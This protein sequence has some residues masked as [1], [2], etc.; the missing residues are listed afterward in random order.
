MKKLITLS[1]CF[2]AIS[3]LLSPLAYAQNKDYSGKTLLDAYKLAGDMKI[4]MNIKQHYAENQ[5]KQETTEK[6]DYNKLD[7]DI[8]VK[9]DDIFNKTFTKKEETGEY[10]AY[11]TE[12]LGGIPA[13]NFLKK[14]SRCT[15]SQT[16][17]GVDDT[18]TPIC[19]NK[20]NNLFVKIRIHSGSITAHWPEWSTEAKRLQESG[21]KKN[22]KKYTETLN[23]WEKW[24]VVDYNTQLLTGEGKEVEIVF[25]DD[26]LM[27]L[28]N[29][30]I[31]IEPKVLQSYKDKGD[32]IGRAN[33]TLAQV[34]YEKG[35]LWGRVLNKDI[36]QFN[37]NNLIAWVRWTSIMINNEWMH[38]IQSKD[39][40]QNAVDIF[41][42]PGKRKPSDSELTNKALLNMG[43]CKYIPTAFNPIII[44][45]PPAIYGS[46]EKYNPRIDVAGQIKKQLQE[47]IKT[48]SPNA[49]GNQKYLSQDRLCD[50]HPLV[51]K[52]SIKDVAYLRKLYTDRRDNEQRTGDNT[53]GDKNPTGIQSS[54]ASTVMK[55]LESIVSDTDAN[56]MRVSKDNNIC[57]NQPNNRNIMWSHMRITDPE[58][59]CR[60]EK[61]V[62]MIVFDNGV[63]TVYVRDEKQ[64]SGVRKVR[65][66]EVDNGEALNSPYKISTRL[67]WENIT[68]K[69]YTQWDTQFNGK[70]AF[71][72]DGKLL[73]NKNNSLINID[74]INTLYLGFKFETACNRYKDKCTSD[75]LVKINNII[76]IEKK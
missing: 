14:S 58:V 49:T 29:G 28:E 22:G 24:Y 15:D 57:K 17:L 43:T 60:D 31:S 45:N 32:S 1:V 42:D 27:R 23:T 69:N 62:G 64:E 47:V 40:N 63:P 41:W 51:L 66:D 76:V 36:V 13:N 6:L 35:L 67:L 38:V 56:E 68:L 53:R 26:S 3:I 18:G 30:S 34:T 61:T 16:V 2:S 73:F 39:N 4:E 54:V 5:K 21:M 59:M 20:N 7:G 44:G 71:A 9:F 8:P 52:H 25:E 11:N 70:I 55:E 75:H 72:H 65:V 10:S 19:G 37:H 48:V 33:N 46:E 74:S 12:R 50:F